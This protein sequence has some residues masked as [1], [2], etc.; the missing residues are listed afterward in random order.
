MAL[1][2]IIDDVRRTPG[3]TPTFVLVHLSCLLALYTGVSWDALVVCGLAFF[4]RGFGVTA[5]FH[6]Y[7]SHRSFKT[8][9]AFQFILAVLGTMSVQK[10]VLWWAAIHRQHHR[11]ADRPGDPHP[12]ARGFVWSHM[13]WFLA[14]DYDYDRTDFGLVRDWMK[15]PELVWLNEHFL[16][17]PL[18]LAAGLFAAGGLPWFVWGF[19]VST[20]LQWHVTY[21]V[22]SIG[23][24]F[25]SR[26]YDTADDSRNNFWLGL[27]A[28]GE[29]WHNN[30]H[31]YQRSVR[32][33]FFWWEIDLSYYVILALSRIGV[34]WD[35]V[36]PPAHVLTAAVERSSRAAA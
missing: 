5:G 16:V 25:G 4:L 2:S 33:G 12:V 14:A 32:Q 13:G 7:F 20:T 31:Y 24:R 3:N 10:G 35:L 23:H 8:S 36:A 30:H 17:P 1:R 26:R 19:C 18:L 21:A 29:G 15:F 34:T 6:R 9:R 28:M 11:E 22:N 27:L